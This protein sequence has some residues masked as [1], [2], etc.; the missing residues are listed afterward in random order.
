M[1]ERVREYWKVLLTFILESLASL[2]NMRRNDEKSL[3]WCIE[4]KS[5]MLV[6]A[7]PRRRPVSSVTGEERRQRDARSH[8]LLHACNNGVAQGAS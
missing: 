1:F 3:P 8:A 7:R 5:K 2:E 4:R 6:A